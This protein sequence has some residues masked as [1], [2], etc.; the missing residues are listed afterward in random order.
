MLH[1][2]EP[3][4]RVPSRGLARCAPRG[5]ARANSSC[6]RPGC[7]KVAHAWNWLS[8]DGKPGVPVGM[9]QVALDAGRQLTCPSTQKRVDFQVPAD[10]MAETGHQLLLGFT[11]G[12]LTTYAQSEEA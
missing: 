12:Y 3:Q 10:A 11:G 9:I 4:F 7:G 2:P 6:R 1:A 5:D 8:N